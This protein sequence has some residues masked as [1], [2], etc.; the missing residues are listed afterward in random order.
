MDLMFSFSDGILEIFDP[1]TATFR[2]DPRDLGSRKKMILLDPVDPGSSLSKLSWD[3][4][5]L[6]S[7]TT[8]NIL[9]LR[10]PTPQS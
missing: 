7:Y 1:V 8:I 9:T 4:A 10:Q 6:G 3:L 2:W 5:D